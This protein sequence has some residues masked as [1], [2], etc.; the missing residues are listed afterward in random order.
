MR[1][2]E[3]RRIEILYLKPGKDV[4]LEC[5]LLHIF[6]VAHYHFAQGWYVFVY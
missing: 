4:F 6:S 1:R 2:T 5:A 3:Q